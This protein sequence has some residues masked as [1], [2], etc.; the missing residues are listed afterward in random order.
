MSTPEIVI[1]SLCMA[2]A[3]A[4]PVYLAIWT[5]GPRRPPV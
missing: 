3:V 1:Y 5:R 4:M 2:V